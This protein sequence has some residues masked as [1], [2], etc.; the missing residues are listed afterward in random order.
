MILGGGTL[1]SVLTEYARLV[2][3][4]A[5]PTPKSVFAASPTLPPLSQFGYL[6][7][8]LALSA[9]RHAQAAVIQFLKDC[10]A[11]GFP[12]DGLYLSS[13]WCQGTSL[14]RSCSPP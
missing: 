3:P 1:P 4:G 9:E 12:V 13:G 6:A 2:S 11:H 10:R 7:S 8:S 5:G 14:L